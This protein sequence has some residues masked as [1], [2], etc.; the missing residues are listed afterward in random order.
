V[1]DSPDRPRG[2]LLHELRT[3]LTQVIGFAELLAE[4]AEE[5]PPRD[6]VPALRR[7]AQAG[8]RLSGLLDEHFGRAGEGAAPAELLP[9]NA[10][11]EARLRTGFERR[12]GRLREAL[13]RCL[14]EEVM[15]D[16]L[17]GGGAVRLH[18][19]TLLCAQM[20]LEAAGDDPAAAHARAASA[21][22]PL[23]AVTADARGIV[24]ALD[25]DGLRAAFGFPEEGPDDAERAV[26]AALRMQLAASEAG[27]P[28]GI[29][30]AR[31][32]VASGPLGSARRASFGI[33]GRPVPVATRLAAAATNGQVLAEAS[34]VDAAGP[35]VVAGE[36]A[37]GAVAI[38]GLAG[39]GG[40]R[41]P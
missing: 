9:L 11:E 41:L 12:S 4:E 5:G 19:A 16:L 3:P 32:R 26:R 30:L 33:V 23:L 35:K 14:G 8:R 38:V 2:S 28:L 13:A 21:I 27:V 22:A 7:I 18:D 17:E 20:R 36:S 34:V 15:T 6:L 10:S 39:V 40:L 37:N 25:G 1:T 31:G 24:W 29:G